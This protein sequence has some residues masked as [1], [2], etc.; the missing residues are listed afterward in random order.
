[1]S[2]FSGT[3]GLALVVYCLWSLSKGITL[4]FSFKSLGGNGSVGDFGVGET[5]VVS[6]SG[7]LGVSSMMVTS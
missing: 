3:L 4:G 2:N 1:M 7:D 6:G 5:G